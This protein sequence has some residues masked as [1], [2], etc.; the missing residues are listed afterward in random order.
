[1]EKIFGWRGKTQVSANAIDKIHDVAD[2]V[3][4]IGY[5]HPAL[6]RFATEKGHTRCDTESGLVNQRRFSQT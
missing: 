2:P 1:M 5:Y 4:E 6:L 3:L